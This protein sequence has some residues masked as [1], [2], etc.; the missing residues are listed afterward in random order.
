M[1]QTEL[2]DV[3]LPPDVRGVV[4]PFGSFFLNPARSQA[5]RATKWIVDFELDDGQRAW[6]AEVRRFLQDNV[7]PALRAEM[8]E[9]G[10]EFQGGEL[11]RVSPQDRRAR[12]VRAELA[13]RSTAAWDSP[14][15]ISTC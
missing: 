11:S 9:H 10:L 1:C 6:L 7:T 13:A 8:A 15:C 12:L 4:V 5:G 14:P 2:H 3:P